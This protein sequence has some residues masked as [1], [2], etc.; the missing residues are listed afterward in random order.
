MH[1]RTPLLVVCMM[2]LALPASIGQ[3]VPAGSHPAINSRADLVQAMDEMQG[4]LAT[5][6][7]SHASYRQ[8]AEKLAGMYS[9]LNTKAQQ[10][11]RA[12]SVVKAGKSDPASLTAL[13]Q[14][15]QQ[16]Q[17]VQAN[18]SLQFQQVQSQMQTADREYFAVSNA[19]KAKSDTVKN[20]INNMR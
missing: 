18:S 11:A 12:A 1:Y 5:L 4:D 15:V 3:K 14:A 17:Q 19:I 8:A 20:S 10:V 9:E 16:L 6:N 7:S 13:Q 2:L